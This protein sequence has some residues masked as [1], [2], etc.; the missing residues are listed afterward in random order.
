MSIFTRVPT[1]VPESR[2]S[3]PFRSRSFEDS[4]GLESCGAVDL[5]SFPFSKMW[6]TVGLGLMGCSGDG[7]CLCAGVRHMEPNTCLQRG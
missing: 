1:R 2:D 3:E 4:A 7:L 6:V 5:L